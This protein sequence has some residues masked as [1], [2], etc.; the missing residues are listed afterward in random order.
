MDLRD[1]VRAIR[2]RWW[3]V[4][5]TLLAAMTLAGVITVHT[6]PQ[7]ASTVTFFVT[8]PDSV[9]YQGG[10]FSQQRVKS[11]ANLLSGDRLAR[12]VAADPSL[13]LTPRQIQA[14]ISA[15]PVP[16]TVLLEATVT[17]SSRSRAQHIAE[18]VAVEFKRLVEILETAPGAPGAGVKVEVV[19]G[20]VAAPAPVA[21]RPIRNLV[22]GALCGLLLGTGF[23][24]L[25]ELLDTT[26]KTPE[27][28][29]NLAGAPVLASVPFDSIARR[30]PLVVGSGKRSPRAEALRQLR[31][32]LQ[33]VD[34]DRP[35][36]SLV[37]TSAVP[38]EGKSST[39]CN[40]AIVFAEAGKRVLLVDADLRRPRLAQYLGVEGAIGLTNVLA[41]QASVE[42]VAQLWGTRLWLLPSGFLPPNP[43]ELLGSQHM[44]DL[45]E[46]FRSQFDIVIIDT[47]PLLPVTD[48]AVAA[49]RADGAVL[50]TRA[51]RTTTSQTDTAVRA[52]QTVD[53]R[54]LGCVFNMV[55]INE[56]DPYHYYDYSADRTEGVGA[57]PMPDTESVLVGV[58]ASPSGPPTEARKESS[59]HSADHDGVNAPSWS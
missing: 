39:A 52:L 43:S 35:I 17:D 28:L 20:P 29:G 5:G 13:N 55:A 18:A 10:L 8:T 54:L 53:A 9:D 26:V 3:I 59:A 37:V 34:V 57:M 14:R 22:L 47:P 21:P 4:V 41:G 58:A 40:L 24:V 36:R 31:T 56:S 48:A 2:K 49:V 25:R 12:A 38:G 19:A 50:V 33:F 42:D 46:S 27:A 30:A 1:Y 16:E 6:V 11:Y 32:N 15:N 7:Y 45:L 23:A 51:G 44:A